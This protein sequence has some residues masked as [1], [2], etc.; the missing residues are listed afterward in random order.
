MV[1]VA[2]YIHQIPTALDM[3]KDAHDKGYE[4][5]LNLM[6]VSTVPE[7]ELDEALEMLGRRPRRRPSTSWTASA[8]L[9]SEQVE[10]LRATISC[11]FAK[12]A[13]KEVGIHAHNNLQLAF[14][15]TIEA[16]ILGANLLDA[17]HGRPRPR[18]GQLPDGAAA[19]FP[20]QPQVHL[21]PVLDC[22]QNH[23]EPMREKLRWGFAIPYMLTGYLN[24]HPQPPSSSW[25]KPTARDVVKFYDSV[26]MPES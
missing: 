9:Y 26:T 20:A 1:R 7:H 10:Y 2:T 12:A 19:G 4:T 14:A 13:G 15:N 3:I 17:T 11:S 6:A 21:R 5:T 24:Q 23:V 25:R 18:R 8:T 22:V 16:I